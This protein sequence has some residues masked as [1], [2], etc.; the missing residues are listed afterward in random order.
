VRIAIL[1]WS[2]R[3]FGGTGTYLSTLM[4][5]LGTAGHDVALW[6]EVERP[7]EHG[8]L[9]VPAAA[10][11]WSVST[12]G[13]EPAIA[14]LREW[15]P[16]LLYA[17]GLLDPF[18]EKRALEVAPA[19]FFAHDYY[20]TCISGLKT[21]A[22]P[23][24]TPCSR[25]FGW[26]CLLAYYPRRCGGLSPVT[27]VRQ[28]RLQHDRLELLSRYRA[29][30]T[31]STHM[32]QEYVKH[33]LSP[34]RVVNVRF[35]A[36]LKACGRSLGTLR[37]KD[38]PWRLLFVGRMDRLKGGVELL[39]ALP[40]V[41]RR[42]GRPLQLTFAGDGPERAAWQLLATRVCESDSKIQTEFRGWIERDA[43][44]ELYAQSDLLVL[45]SLWPEPLALVGLEAARHHIPA[46]AFDVGGVSEWL[47][48][49]VNGIL[50]PGDPPTVEALATAI[51]AALHDPDVHARLAEGA[52]KRSADFS[53]DLH[54]K[55]LMQV[56]ENVVQ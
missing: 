35:G 44:E 33:G 42:L 15:Q 14:A 20:G 38:Q 41:A 46:V 17:H 8:I 13:L 43:I 22:N 34:S 1:N 27:M 49:G 40:D 6:H 26:Q 45:P 9:P 4:P 16:D 10:P 47:T 30:V 11:M 37:S 36:H 3:R 48:S 19:V 29:I 21:F 50:A 2:N 52:G 54:V 23:V 28:F 39:Q 32:Q 18:V 25:R 5:A 51:V 55:R 7:S 56:F 53:F 31:H 24:V 12:L